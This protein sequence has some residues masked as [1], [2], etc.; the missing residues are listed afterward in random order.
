MRQL[1]RT[2][3]LAGLVAVL[4]VAGALPTYAQLTI[5]KASIA[6]GSVYIGPTLKADSFYV[7]NPTQVGYTIDK[8]THGSSR[9]TVTGTTGVVADSIKIRVTFLPDSVGTY[10]DT[11][12]IAHSA[13]GGVFTVPLSATVISGIVLSS[14]RSGGTFTT[15][16][17][18]DTF[19]MRSRTDSLTIRNGSGTAFTVSA[20][21]I[22]NKEFTILTPVPFTVK[23]S[24][25]ARVMI[26]YQGTSVGRDKDT[27]FITH[28]L[29]GKGTSPLILPVTG[30][31]ISHE[32]FYQMS[33]D[34]ANTAARVRILH[35]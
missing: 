35:N 7:K 34:V 32:L 13:A 27:L 10:A 24:D 4:L 26:S 16:S 20:M 25:S 22:A 23:A 19:A 12:V 14:P 15:F 31:A 9:F 5:S 2:V 6:F 33:T 18:A 1:T 28:N 8:I 30:R 21:S 17:I 3:I 11:V 29:P